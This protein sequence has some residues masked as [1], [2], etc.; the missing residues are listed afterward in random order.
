[1]QTTAKLSRAVALR[2][3][4]APNREYELNAVTTGGASLGDDR[5]YIGVRYKLGFGNA[6]HSTRT[7]SPERRQ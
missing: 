4:T 7:L 1:M 6:R 5:G 3:G 2:A